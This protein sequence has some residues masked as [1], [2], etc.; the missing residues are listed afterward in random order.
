[1]FRRGKYAGKRISCVPPFMAPESAVTL[2]F[3]FLSHVFCCCIL[4]QRA[5]TS[6]FQYKRFNASFSSKCL[7]QIWRFLALQPFMALGAGRWA[8]RLI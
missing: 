7:W 8:A 5:M 1:M 6:I 3:R 2:I 4:R